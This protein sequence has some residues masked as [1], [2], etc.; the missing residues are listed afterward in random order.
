MNAVALDVF[1]GCRG[2]TLYGS[3]SVSCAND[4]ALDAFSE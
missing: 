4:V 3:S 2:S 1:I